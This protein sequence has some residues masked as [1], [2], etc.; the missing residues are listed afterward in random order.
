MNLLDNYLKGDYY[1]VYDEIVKLGNRAFEPD[2]FPTVEAVLIETFTRVSYNL[3]IIY[4]ELVKIDYCFN[5][6]TKY[7]FQ[8]PLL[9]PSPDAK[10]LLLKLDNVVK[11][12]GHIPLSLKMFYKIVG[13]CNFAWD[14]NENPNIPWEGADPIQIT[15]VTDL[16][17]EL[18][19]LSDEEDEFIQLCVSADY[20][21]KDNISGGPPYCVELTPN[22]SIDGLFL[23]QEDGTTFINYLRLTMGNCGFSRPD[24]CIHIDDFA[25]FQ[26]NVRPKLYGI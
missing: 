26:E 12:I 21:H 11:K 6:R 9:K 10:D 20:L 22:L 1:Y 15:P 18:T 8:R 23:N 7:D 17:S 3:D 13:S 24:V 16:L 14:Y 4:A 2:F 25:R 19:S 5:R